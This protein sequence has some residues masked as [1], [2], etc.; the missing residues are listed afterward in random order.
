VKKY[1]KK[2]GPRT[3]GPQS[4]DTKRAESL[5]LPFT[6][7]TIIHAPVEEFNDMLTKTKLT[8]AQV[9][10]IIIIKIIII[11]I[12]LLLGQ[13][14]IIVFVSVQLKCSQAGEL[15]ENSLIS[16]IFVSTSEKIRQVF[17]LNA[18]AFREFLIFQLKFQRFFLHCVLHPGSLP[19]DYFPNVI[20]QLLFIVAV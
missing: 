3:K 4:R 6:V 18:Y 16:E 19:C 20:A 5:K 2:D 8:E 11:I 10:M 13:L 17:L 9:I 15:S 1:A 12:L 7:D 14:F